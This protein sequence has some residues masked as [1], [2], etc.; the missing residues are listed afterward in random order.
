MSVPSPVR[1]FGLVSEEPLPVLVLGSQRPDPVTDLRAL[2]PIDEVEAVSA[3]G[4]AGLQRELQA[5]GPLTTHGRGVDQQGRPGPR[6]IPDEG[7]KVP[8]KEMREGGI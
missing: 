3:G 1:L 6:G 4:Q 5:P 2:G 8:A 7:G